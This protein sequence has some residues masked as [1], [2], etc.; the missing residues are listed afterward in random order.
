MSLVDLGFVEKCQPWRLESRFFPSKVGGRPAWLNLKNIPR[1][2]DLECEYCR[3]PCIFLCQI[4]APY[5]EDN[6]A[7]HR[8]LFNPFYPSEPPVEEEDWKTDITIDAWCKTCCVCGIAAPNHC[9]K[10]K[11]TNYCCRNHQVYDWKQYHKHNCGNNVNANN[12]YLFPEYELVIET[13][14]I[15]ETED[16]ED[17]S[18]IE[19]KELAKYKSMAQLKETGCIQGEKDTEDLSRMANPEE[20]EV[21]ALFRTRIEQN[22]EQV[23]RYERNGQILYISGST[24][25]KDVP[26]CSLCGGERQFEFQIMPQLLNFLNYKDVI[27]SLDWGILVI[28]TCKKSCM[29]KEEYAIEYIWKQDILPDKVDNSSVNKD[30]ST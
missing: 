17:C 5:E 18:E 6:D 16:D 30:D 27:N 3:N 10:C 8:T 2:E 22:P 12:S 26:K 28:F 14:E 7:F 15:I 1:K 23:L 20:D 13:E 9:S 19:E 25:I 29:P 11:I 21:F 4:Y 24:K